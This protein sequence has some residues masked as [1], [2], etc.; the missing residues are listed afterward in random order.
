MHSCLL[1]CQGI[2]APYLGGKIKAFDG[3]MNVAALPDPNIAILF[4]H[5]AV[6]KNYWM[7]NRYQVI[8]SG[9][10]DGT[11]YWRTDTKSLEDDGIQIWQRLDVF[12]M[13]GQSVIRASILRWW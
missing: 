8:S 5:R 12:P 11:V 10:A 4:Y 9:D 1:E 7:G 2:T 3:D 13:F 6:P